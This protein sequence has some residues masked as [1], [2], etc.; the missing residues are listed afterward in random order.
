MF[1]SILKRTPLYIPLRQLRRKW[2]ARI[3]IRNWKQAGRPAPPPEAFKRKTV[4]AIGK[5]RGLVT[6]IETGTFHGDMVNACKKAFKTIVS[7]ELSP[8]LQQEN[9]ERF[10]RF[11]GIRIIHGDGA[12][13]LPGLLKEI[14]PP[15]LFWLDGHFTP[16]SRSARGDIETPIMQELDAIFEHPHESNVVLID[17]ARLFIGTHDFPT[18]DDV[19]SVVSERMPGWSFEVKDDIIRIYSG[20]CLPNP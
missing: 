1:I 3:A 14:E 20:S 15:C 2:L 18:L 5:E 16:A 4:L 12:K 7:I 13:I 9:A 17:D 11:P 6:L 19:R 10:S 8:Q